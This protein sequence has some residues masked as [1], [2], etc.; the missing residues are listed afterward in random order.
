MSK[1]GVKFNPNEVSKPIPKSSIN[2]A[3]TMRELTSQLSDFNRPRCGC[4]KTKNPPYC[5]GSHAR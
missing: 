2:S 5:D 3:A 1:E 4:G